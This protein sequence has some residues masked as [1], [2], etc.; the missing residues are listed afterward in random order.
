LPELIT[1]LPKSGRFEFPIALLL[2]GPGVRHITPNRP[3]TQRHVPHPNCRY[4]VAHVLSQCAVRPRDSR[5]PLYTLF[6]TL[7]VPVS[8]LVSL[9]YWFL[10]TDGFCRADL[11]RRYCPLPTFH[12]HLFTRQHG[13]TITPHARAS[14]K[15]GATQGQYG[16]TAD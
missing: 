9:L 14:Y 10:L 6:A 13:V 16:S 8:Q 4:R 11:V 3:V 15:S 2:R 12:I 1:L 7:V 5:S